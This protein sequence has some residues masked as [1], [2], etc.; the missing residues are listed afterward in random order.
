MARTLQD[1]LVRLPSTPP[2]SRPQR[3]ILAEGKPATSTNAY[4]KLLD[5][6][7]VQ[8]DYSHSPKW[9]FAFWSHHKS[10]WFSRAVPRVNIYLFPTYMSDRYPPPNAVFG[11]IKE[12]V[13]L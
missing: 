13:I 7:Y 12:D 5:F 4:G 1:P 10:E 11:F 9:K 3:S 6:S 2:T 8:I